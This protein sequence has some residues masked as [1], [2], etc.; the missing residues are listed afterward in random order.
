MVQPL[1]KCGLRAAPCRRTSAALGRA[2]STSPRCR[3]AARCSS[4][5][6]WTTGTPRSTRRAGERHPRSGRRPRRRRRRTQR[7]GSPRARRGEQPGAG[8][9]PDV[10]AAGGWDARSRWPRSSA[11]PCGRRPRPAAVG[12]GS[13]RPTRTSSGCSRPRSGRFRDARRPRPGAG[14]RLGGVPLLPYF[15][16]PLLAES[17]SLIAINGD[18]VEARARPDGGRDRRATWRSRSEGPWSSRRGRPRAG[19]A[20]PSLGPARARVLAA[21]DRVGGD[22]RARRRLARRRDRGGGVAG[23]HRR[24]AQP[25]ADLA[26]GELLLQLRRRAR[27]RI[28]RSRSESS[29]LRAAARSCACSGRARLSTAITALWTAAAYKVPV[30]YL[31]IRTTSTRSSSGS[32]MSSR[33]RVPRGSTCPSSTS[34]RSPPATG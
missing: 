6:R 11:C 33:S 18:P 28:A 8:R 16:G 13:R 15:P 14:R 9:G 20:R 22:G 24:A 5:S 30:T 21:D 3:R 7:H 12:S 23:E 2:A 34:P 19:R 26:A 10:D 25:A 4:R 31:V 32:P 1:V 27:V 29:S 17:T